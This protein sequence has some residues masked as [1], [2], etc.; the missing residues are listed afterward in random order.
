MNMPF[1]DPIFTILLLKIHGYDT[2]QE[3]QQQKET[4]G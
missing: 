1:F 2:G 4:D 3:T